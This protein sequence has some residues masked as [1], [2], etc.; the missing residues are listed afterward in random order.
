MDRG[1]NAVGS[2]G[3]LGQSTSECS[4]LPILI[5]FLLAAWAVFFEIDSPNN[6]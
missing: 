1:P 2:P 4:G 5:P 3:L 6:S